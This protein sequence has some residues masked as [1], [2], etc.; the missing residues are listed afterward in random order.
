[1]TRIHLLSLSTVQFDR[2]LIVSDSGEHCI[3]GIERN[4]NFQYK[5]GKKCAGDGDFNNPCCLSLN[6]ESEHLMV[7]DKENHRIQ[8]FQLNGTF[9]GQFGTKGS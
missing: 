6:T 9:L 1:M 7:S 5:F 2:Y 8:V 4:G 3:K